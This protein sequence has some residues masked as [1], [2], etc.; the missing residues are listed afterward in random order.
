MLVQCTRAKTKCATVVLIM[1]TFKK[2]CFRILG[3]QSLVHSNS[4][5]LGDPV[6]LYGLEEA[7]EVNQPVHVAQ[8]HIYWKQWKLNDEKKHLTYILT[9]E[10]GKIH[11]VL[12]FKC[13]EYVPFCMVQRFIKRSVHM[14]AFCLHL[15]NL[16]N[17]A[18][19]L[20]DSIGWNWI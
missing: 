8:K 18:M 7:T 5:K 12:R 6:P 19:S 2:V 9:S 3:V 15:N 14:F 1:F 13:T 10:K 17:V 20:L 4:D 11:Y 16:Q